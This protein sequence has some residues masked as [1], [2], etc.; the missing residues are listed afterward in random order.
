MPDARIPELVRGALDHTERMLHAQTI[1]HLREY[2]TV[3]EWG[4]ALEELCWALD[5]LAIPIDRGTWAL[6][7]EACTLMADEFRKDVTRVR[8]EDPSSTKWA[9]SDADH[10]IA[11]ALRYAVYD[12]EVPEADRARIRASIDVG[13]FRAAFEDLRAT[14]S[15]MGA[16]EPKTREIIDATARAVGID[17]AAVGID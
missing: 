13:A 1:E 15:A 6:L 10:A 17:V 2:V 3:G 4:I 14:L 9:M 11:R 12:L 7:D 8:L 16:L 5:E